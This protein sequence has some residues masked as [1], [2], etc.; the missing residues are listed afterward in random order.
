MMLV[1]QMMPSTM[2]DNLCSVA[3]C[4]QLTFFKLLSVIFLFYFELMLIMNFSTMMAYISLSVM[5]KTTTSQSHKQYSVGGVTFKIAYPIFPEI[6]LIFCY[7][8]Y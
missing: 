6:V 3:W 1:F 5:H 7:S 2:F 4:G 8:V